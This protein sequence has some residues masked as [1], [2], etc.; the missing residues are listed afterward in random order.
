MFT[1]RNLTDGGDSMENPSL[2]LLWEHLFSYFLLY[3]SLI[4]ILTPSWFGLLLEF[5][6]IFWFVLILEIFQHILFVYL[7]KSMQMRMVI[8]I[9]LRSKWWSSETSVALRQ[10]PIT[11][12]YNC[13]WY[14]E[15]ILKR[16]R[17]DDCQKTLDFDTFHVSINFVCE[18]CG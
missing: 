14:C 3:R 11:N 16:G 7:Y 17:R 15:A 9:K 10:K 12:K 1:Q 18:C 5:A 4:L 8:S 2:L 6:V 13:E